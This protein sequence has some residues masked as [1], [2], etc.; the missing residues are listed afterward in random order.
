MKFRVS[1]PTL[2]LLIRPCMGWCL[3]P[4]FLT[5]CFLSRSVFY[6]REAISVEVKSVDSGDS[7]VRFRS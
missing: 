2:D 5:S 4:M 3:E 1:G 7:L 6:P